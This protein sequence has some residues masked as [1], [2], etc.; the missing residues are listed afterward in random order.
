MSE[1][2]HDTSI[3]AFET[4]EASKLAETNMRAVVLMVRMA[5]AQRQYHVSHEFVLVP[6]DYKQDE[7]SFHNPD[8][9]RRIAG[10]S[11]EIFNH[12]I[13]T[14]RRTPRVI[15]PDDKTTT[16]QYVMWEAMFEGRTVNIVE[17]WW[18]PELPYDLGISVT[19]HLQLPPEET[20]APAAEIL[21]EIVQPD[22]PRRSRAGRFLGRL[23]RKQ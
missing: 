2:E 13:P 9:V 23:Y 21:P 22:E 14:I 4:F 6:D 12:M 7:T 18:E 1:S 15:D 10:H 17:K 11:V 8:D 5:V 16:G 19:A 3:E 20:V